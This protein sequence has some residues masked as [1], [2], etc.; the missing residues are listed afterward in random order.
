[1]HISSLIKES[2]ASYAGA[3]NLFIVRTDLDELLFFDK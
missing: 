3:L 2:K 1:M